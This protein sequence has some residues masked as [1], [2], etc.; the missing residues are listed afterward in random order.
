MPQNTGHEMDDVSPK[1]GGNLG[2]L[3]KMDV[4]SIKRPGGKRTAESGSVLAC[5]KHSA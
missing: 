5:T 2:F 4:I 3:V 1:R